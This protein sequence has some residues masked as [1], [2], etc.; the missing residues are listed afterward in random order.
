MSSVYAIGSK[1]GATIGTMESSDDTV[2]VMDD[3]NSQS[4][5][6]KEIISGS[7]FCIY[8]DGNQNFWSSGEN[9]LGE[10][11]TNDFEDPEE[12]HAIG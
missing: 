12:P 8:T 5:D 9:S 11:C 10:C 2:L 7:F 3:I 1:H 6:I 4:Q